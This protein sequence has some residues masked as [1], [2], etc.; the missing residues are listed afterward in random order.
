MKKNFFI[1]MMVAFVLILM[2]LPNFAQAEGPKTVLEYTNGD[3]TIAI[4]L[5]EN[6]ASCSTETTFDTITVTGLPDGWAARG[7]FNVEYV[8]DDGRQ[9]VQEYFFNYDLNPGDQEWT[10]EYPPVTEWPVLNNSNPPGIREIHVDQAI[11]VY[12]ENGVN[13]PWV[14]SSDIPGLVGPGLNLW[15]VYCVTPPEDPTPTPTPTSTPTPPPPTGGEGC[16]PGFWK[17][18]AEKRDADR[19]VG[20][21]PSNL[22]NA[23]VFS[24]G[25]TDVNLLQALDMNGGGANALLRHSTAALLNAA[26]PDVSYAYTE[27][28]IK[29]WVQEA[30]NSGEFEGLKDKL[31]E[32]NNAGCPLPNNG[33]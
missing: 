17:N 23:D 21:S 11:R 3:T 13:V 33:K 7:Y 15:D 18:N 16:T 28:E 12:D 8:T 14:A 32:A 29:S 10:I 24:V 5:P 26:N 2:V 1:V 20:Y 25:P 22:Y 6:Y 31:D 30:F 27:D 9:P 19:W 4:S